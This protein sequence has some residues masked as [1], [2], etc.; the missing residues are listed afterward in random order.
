[1]ID[2]WTQCSVEKGQDFYRQAVILIREDIKELIDLEYEV[3]LFRQTRDREMFK[4]IE[5]NFKKDLTS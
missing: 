4:R 2:N 3:N 5:K 1:M